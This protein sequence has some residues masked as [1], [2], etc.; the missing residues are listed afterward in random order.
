ME[1]GSPFIAAAD[2]GE[3]GRPFAACWPTS[4]DIRLPPTLVRG[5]DN[6][7]RVRTARPHR[8]FWP[9]PPAEAV[10][11]LWFKLTTIAQLP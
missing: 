11:G 5:A 7:L 6:T 4:G 2:R 8:L 1:A 9:L 3:C 10:Y